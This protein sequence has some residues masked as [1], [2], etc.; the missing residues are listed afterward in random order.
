[1]D[2]IDGPRLHLVLWKAFKAMEA[3]DRASIRALGFPSLS[4]F[5]LLEV[6][7]HKGPCPVNEIGR[8]VYLTSGSI[9]SAVDR[10]VERGWV[11]RVPRAEDRRVVEV[12]LTAAGRAHIEAAF[13]CHAK[14]LDRVVTAVSAEDRVLLHRL[15]KQLGNAAEG[16]LAAARPG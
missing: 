7:L 11:E 14:A 15:L 13:A 3:V 4:D 16:H 1:M 6:L 9:S 12:H 5:A 10:A 8:R 2:A